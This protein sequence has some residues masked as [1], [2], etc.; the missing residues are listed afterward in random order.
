ML[1]PKALPQVLDE[2]I[3]PGVKVVTLM[4]RSGLQLGSAG[5]AQSA[6]VISA[7][8]SNLWQCHEKCEG[9]GSLSCLLVE[10]EEGRL[11]VA[12]VS[13]FV[14]SCC[15]D[16]TMP[17]GLLKAKVEA[18]QSSLQPSLSRLAV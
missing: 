18:L 11:A 13:S 1:D 12:A 15:A 10:C 9:S 14:L 2:A 17:F 7:I 6:M 16:S 4:N 8:A 5:D 3:S